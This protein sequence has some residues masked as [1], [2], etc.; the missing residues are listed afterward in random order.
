MRRRWKITAL[1]LLMSI[2][3]VPLSAAAEEAP[4]PQEGQEIVSLLHKYD[5]TDTAVVR[6]VDPEERTVTLCQHELGRYYTLHYDNTS[7][8]Y[9]KHRRPVSATLLQPGEV[10]DATF[11]HQSKHLN[12]LV[13]SGA[14]WEREDLRVYQIDTEREM[15]SFDGQNYHLPPTA[16]LLNRENG[17]GERILAEEILDGDVLCVS[18]IDKE[19]YSVVVTSG[20]GYLRLTSTQVGD[21]DIYGAWINLDNR[22][23]Q[24]VNSRTLLA[25]PEGTY[26]MQIIG[27]GANDSRVVTIE[28]GRETVIDSSTIRMETPDT[29]EI[30]IEVLP[31]EAEAVIKADGK[32]IPRGMPA[33]LTQGVHTIEV[34]AE[35]YLPMTK[36]IKVGERPSRLEFTLDEDT[37]AADQGASTGA[38]NAG[39]AGTTDI[40]ATAGTSDWWNSST[41]YTGTGAASASATASTA[42]STASSTASSAATAASTGSSASTAATSQS[43]SG[44]GASRTS[45]TV[46][47]PSGNETIHT[48]IPGYEVRVE[49]PEGVEFYM[50]GN[51]MGITPTSFVKV[52]GRHTVTLSRKG[53]A[54]KSYNIY[55]DDADSNKTYAFPALEPLEPEPD[56]PEPEEPEPEEPEPEEPEPEEPE[57]SE[58]EEEDA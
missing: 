50:D 38:T 24:R 23:I 10:V 5:S 39:T 12:S 36:R 35:G 33:F 42:G 8:I 27:Q 51:Y 22:V 55:I 19:I 54:T 11:L 31:E 4:A 46:V 28:R 21:A 15:I 53:Y 47:D 44:T 1:L 7:M 17:I 45:V 18:G 13:G 56:V 52:S 6:S 34:S 25:A 49:S 57:P 16:L 20:H 48:T 3:S 43:G 2:W 41:G 29:T 30:T 32:E 40:A 58:P 26:N 14:V 37:T 9:D